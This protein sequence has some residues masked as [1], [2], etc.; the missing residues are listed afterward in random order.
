MPILGDPI[1]IADVQ[2]VIDQ[3]LKAGKGARPDGVSPG[4]FKLLPG[5]WV[6]FLC[7]LHIFNWLS[8][9]LGPCKIDHVIQEG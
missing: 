2:S 6:M 8:N 1:T 7:T 5:E 4:V 3:Q 9:E